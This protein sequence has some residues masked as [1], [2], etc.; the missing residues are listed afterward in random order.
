MLQLAGKNFQPLPE[1]PPEERAED[2]C[3]CK[4]VVNPI[5]SCL[6]EKFLDLLLSS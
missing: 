2:S 3:C 1:P 6:E 4:W 5:C